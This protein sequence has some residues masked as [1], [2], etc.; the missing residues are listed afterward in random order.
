MKKNTMILN[1]L[2]AAVLGIWLLTGMIWKTFQPNVILPKPDLPLMT[3]LI[4]IA[5]FLEYLIMGSGKHAWVPQTVLA[6]VTFC[7]LPLAA[8]AQ[9]FG[10]HTVVCG[11]A[12]F[13]ILTVLFDWAAERIELSGNGRGAVAATVLGMYLACQC[14]QGML[15]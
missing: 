8:G 12:A 13:G 9:T 5:L 14:F 7:V 3:A 11:A 6:A 4:L 10:I 15:L 2:L 1:G